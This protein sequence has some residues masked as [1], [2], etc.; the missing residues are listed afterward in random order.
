MAKTDTSERWF[1]A[2]VVRG[3]TGTP[4]PEYSH[5]LAPTDFAATH[6]GYTQGNPGDYNRDVVLDVVKL[7]EFLQA[8]QPKAVETLNLAVDGIQRTQFLHRL[9]G[10][11][12]KRGVVDVLRKGVSHGP[13]TVDL[14]KLLPTPGNASAAEAFG[15][16]IFSV[17]RQLRYSNDSGNELDMAIFINGLPVLTFELKNSL[18][19]Q[20]VADAI[21][22]Y[23]TTRDPRELLFQSGRCVA[24]IAVDDAE[25][26][27]CTELKGKA[28]WFLPF[29]QGWN[30]G[31]GNPPNPNGL[32][33]D[34]LWKQVLTKES[35][36]NIIENYAQVVEDE[37]EDVNGRR[38]KTRKPVFPRFHQLRTVLALLR[39]SRADGVGQ[40][41]L[42]QHSAGSGK[43]NTIAWLAHQL[44]ELKTAAD[45][46]Q[47][48]FDSVIVITDRRALDTQIHKTI[49]GYDHVASILGHS[50]NAQE[51]REYLRRGKK[52]IVTTVQKFPFILDELGDLGDRKFALLIDEA[53]SSQGGKTTAKM[54]QAL[55]GS[56]AAEGDEED[57]N[58]IQD[59]INALIEERI[60][61]RK[62]LSNASY[63]AFT[64]TPKTKTLELFGEKQRVGDKVQS[65]SPEELTY[66]TKQAIQEGFIL[67]VVANY[68][69]VDSFYHVA[70]TI[71]DDPELDKVKALK[72]IRR[73]VES[74]DKAIRHKA[75][76][77]I[78][79][80]TAQVIGAKKIGG[81][82][83]AMIVCNGIARA[84]D[85]F[86]E[87]SDYLT[88]TKSP[89]KAIV[90]Y[91]G[92]FEIGGAK[93]TEADLNGFP[94]KDIPAKL[95]QDPYRFLIV[96]NKFVTGFDEPLLHTMYVDKSL[97]GVLAVQT[98]SRLNRAH[99]QKA[100]T[101]VLDFADNAEAVKAAFQD[102]YRAT[103]QDGET[104]PNKLHDLKSE[105]DGQQVY[106][107]QQVDDL[108]ALY[109]SGADRDKLD[110][111]LD[112]C[113][114]E[115]TD[116]LDE[117]DQVK[118]KGKAKAF[119]RSY[120]FL[121]AILPYGHPAWEKLSIFLNFLIPKLPAPKEEDLSKGVLEAIDMDSYRAQAQAAM[122]MT[123]DDADAFVEPPPPGGGGGGGEPELDRLSNIIK[124]FNDLFGNIEW[125]D[126]DK[127]RKVI[128][129]EIPARVAQDKAYQNAQANSGK[130]NAR[131]EH[132]KTLNRVVLEL[133][134]DHTELFKQFSDNPNFKRW[135]ANMVFDTTYRPSAPP[136]SG[137]S[138]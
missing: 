10:E 4:Q 106:S 19:K 98:L 62:L 124:Q 78:D 74:H 42:I 43:S 45:E 96:A 110:P 108:V 20:T 118:F 70:K 99:P 23:Q 131:L 60:H 91:S 86:R 67:D 76:I 130:Q 31:A 120:G 39:R 14:Y 109:L 82:A 65:R 95:K 73:Y 132:D 102:Y 113:V 11:I 18:T 59:E 94:S 81:K 26:R 33:T 25:V 83:R 55:G 49:K 92:E 115:Y 85:Y 122:K 46:T 75:E 51:L 1:E 72:K 48:Q 35:L 17:T 12:A 128:V 104:D 103:I 89:Y 107:A 30:S 69:P 6:N 105:L 137:T 53:H 57:E 16:N 36:A 9:Q 119:V 66:T 126:A 71:E 56:G 138:A 28:S 27:F 116:K 64:A 79:H 80:F 13:V 24:H 100:D 127:I 87:V 97:A 7:F 50:D 41:Y 133:L 117:E 5:A 90:A 15:K 123:M 61:S 101:F 121:S 52:I 44:V 134:D 22:Q 136:Q 58:D 47:P 111:I 8:T 37:E 40:R 2:R 38:R 3:L 54:H 77:M 112:V 63:Y 21:V 88:E 84:I 34:Y 93:K 129:E 135:L 114:A 68:T 125:H 32:K 29:N